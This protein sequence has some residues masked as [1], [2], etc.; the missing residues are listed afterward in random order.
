VVNGFL[1][2]KETSETISDSAECNFQ[3]WC[4]SHRVPHPCCCHPW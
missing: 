3:L 4:S 1:T 2:E